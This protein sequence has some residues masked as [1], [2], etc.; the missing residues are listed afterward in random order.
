MRECP[1]RADATDRGGQTIV[2]WLALLGLLAARADSA[3]PTANAK[4]SLE[5]ALAQLQVPPAWFDEVKVEYDVNRPW[6]EARLEVR[7]LL[8]LN[9]NREAIKLTVLY[10]RKGDIGDGHEYPMYLYMGGEYAWAVQ[11]YRQRLAS[12]PK[13]YT[14]EYLCLA[15]CY[16]HF[17][18]YADALALLDVAAQRLPDP[19]WRIAQEADICDYRGDL[20]AEMGDFAQARQQYEKAIALYPTSDQPYGRHLL[21]RRAAKVQSKLDL[22][23]MAAIE[24]AALRDG[25]YVAKSL[26]YV[27]DLTV[28][29]TIR[30]G[31][32]ADIRIQHEE[33]IDQKATTIIPQ[34]IIAAQ[35]LKVDGITG[36]T[37]TY[38]AIIDGALQALRKAGLK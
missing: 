28:T 16:R 5:E 2:L 33:K 4:P 12:Q 11:E 18:R 35:S 7:R 27:G 15:A 29:V 32:I 26:G 20:Y 21:H 34:R 22:L 13:G 19:P 10:V 31:K 36:A 3:E 6:K 24:S 30:A 1:L 14:H 17:G 23:A 38:D 9:Q 8:S 25:T 37:V